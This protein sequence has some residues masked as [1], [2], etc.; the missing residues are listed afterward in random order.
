MWGPLVTDVPL[1]P[2]FADSPARGRKAEKIS[3]NVAREI[4][5]DIRGQGMK[6]G[7]VLPAE[8]VMLERFGIGRSSLR[9]ALRILEVNGLISIKTGPGGGPIV[10]ATDAE[11]FGRVWSM[12]LQSVDTT[13]REL[14]ES[15]S[16]LE[17]ALARRAAELKSSAPAEV[18]RNSA[19]FTDREAMLDDLR[20]AAVTRE[21]HSAICHAGKNPVLAL[22]AI[23][24]QSIWSRQVASVSYPVDERP[25]VLEGY[26]QIART[27]ESGDGPQSW[28][29]VREHMQ[30]YGAYCDS[31][32]P[33]R[34]DEVVD[35]G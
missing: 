27:I 29:L 32:Y 6:V 2:R 35:W 13:Y 18:V 26:T 14:L 22:S 4:L 30:G 31:R 5:R 23:S 10:A 3:E 17:S 21:F 34:M 7:D 19:V 20:Y 15:W 28:R 33:A 9:E 16:E 12:H 24:I 8:A 11:S 25:A 1:V